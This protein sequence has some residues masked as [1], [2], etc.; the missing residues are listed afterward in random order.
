MGKAVGYIR[1][2][3]V[4][5]VDDGV[6][7]EMQE[8]KIRAW[9]DLNEHDLVEVYVDEGISGGNDNRPGLLAAMEAVK[10]HKCALV[11]YS[12][13]RISRSTIH[14]LTLADEIQK[15]NGDLVTLQER[16]DTSSPTG[17][18]VFRIMSA[19]NEFER[20]VISERTSEAMQHMKSQGKRVGS[21]P[22]GY[23]LSGDGETL[24]KSER[25]QEVVK[26][27]RALR[28][29]GY[30]LRAISD[31]LSKR[32]VFSRNGKPFHPQTVARIAAA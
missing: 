14:M 25:E 19:M 3:T 18:M 28:R 15:A 9:A 27:V 4:S 26:H 7:L 16:I 24:S 32:G 11:A 6:S 31:E 21:I 10:K 8:A 29:D 17:K 22:Y 5:Q 30:T 12:M 13:S 2:S 23:Q 20:D 1:V